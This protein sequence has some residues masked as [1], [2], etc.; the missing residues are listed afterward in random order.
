MNIFEAAK[1][2]KDDKEIRRSSWEADERID[3]LSGMISKYEWL[4]SYHLTHPKQSI[5]ECLKKYLMHDYYS[6]S[7]EDLL[8][9]DWEVI[10]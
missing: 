10:D 1:Y 8:A 9:E 5:E 4:S 6:I 2:L 7:L 3:E